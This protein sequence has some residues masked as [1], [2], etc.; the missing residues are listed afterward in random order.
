MVK[1]GIRQVSLKEDRAEMIDILS[2][3]FGSTQEA[4]FDWRHRDNPAGESWS[5]FMYDKATLST[6]AMATVFPRHMRVNDKAT[7][8]GQ[9][10]DF[11][12]DPSH[13]SLGPA[14]MLQRA[15][16]LPVDRKE[17]SFC[18][19]CPPHDQGMSTFVRIGLPANCEVYRYALPLRC[20]EYLAKRIGDSSWTRPV[21]V[22][23][24]LLLGL[25]RSGKRAPGLEICR[26]SRAFDKEF[27]HLDDLASVPSAIRSSRSARDLNWR[28]VEDPLASLGSSEEPIRRYQ[29]LVARRGGE[30]KAF[31]AFLIQ[32]DGIATLLDLFGVELSEVGP[33]LLD[34][35]VE[36]CREEG[37]S[38]LHGFC[39][40]ESEL[41]RLFEQM[42]FS[43]RER[44]SR[45][46]AYS[47][48]GLAPAAAHSTPRWMFS[49]VEVML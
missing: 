18:Y 22:A 23:G 29:V 34:A 2:R 8:A 46:V 27:D 26:Q 7:R 21:A 4:R 9:V 35:V 47:K 49:Q 14:I 36:I 44:N 10:G 6:V 31:A 17:I 5:W 33:A 30:L 39:S 42:G 15:T 43:R 45:V 16:F 48:E 25:R 38:S 12:V 41:A 13:R 32:T 40:T 11:V 3:N 1:L 20:D 28:Y 24:N 19:D 37:V